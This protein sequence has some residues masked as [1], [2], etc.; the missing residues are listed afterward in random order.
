MRAFAVPVYIGME[1]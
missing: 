1:S